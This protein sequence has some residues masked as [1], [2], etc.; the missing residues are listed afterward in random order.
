MKLFAIILAFIAPF[1][2]VAQ[3]KKDIKDAGVISRTEKTC[4]TEKGATVTF[5]ESVE[6][7]DENGNKVEVIEY[8]S[9]G[10][11]KVYSQ[12]VYND[13]GKLVK[14]M[15]IDPISKNPI[16]TIEYTYDEKDKLIKELHYN[17]KK[18][19][20]KTVTYTYDNTLKTE[21]KV[22]DDKGKTIETK[23]YTYEKK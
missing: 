6:R 23:T 14:E 13:K 21:K 11:I 8:K 22:V 19:L 18:E 17:K 9:N 3:S 16:V 20:K 7:Y 2:I 1:T 12:F 4:K 10:D 5:T 15:A